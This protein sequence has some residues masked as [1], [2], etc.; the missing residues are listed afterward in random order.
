MNRR[1]SLLATLLLVAGS[2][3]MGQQIAKDDLIF[4]TPQWQGE[5]F[6]TVARRYRTTSSS[7]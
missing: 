4:L 2:P 3:V 5:R 1:S 6:R 7:G